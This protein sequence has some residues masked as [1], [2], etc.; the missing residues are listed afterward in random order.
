M[1]A[2][3]FLMFIMSV[4]SL[5]GVVYGGGLMVHYKMVK[6]DNVSVAYFAFFAV[7]CAAIFMFSML[8]LISAIVKVHGG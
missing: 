6:E 2:T 7:L 5:V 3:L 4:I 8:I 1:E